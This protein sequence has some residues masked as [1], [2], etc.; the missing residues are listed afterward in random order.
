MPKNPNFLS[1]GKKII[2]YF[3]LDCCKDFNFAS[4]LVIE[5]FNVFSC[6]LYSYDI[7]FDIPFQ[8]DFE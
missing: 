2:N 3:L 1:W 6:F 8:N 4:L 7:F 5:K